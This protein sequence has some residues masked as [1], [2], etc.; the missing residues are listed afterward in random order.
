MKQSVKIKGINAMLVI[1]MIWMGS[2]SY[3][4]TAY[5][6]TTSA[7]VQETEPAS[8]LSRIEIEGIEL[9]Q[10]FSGDLFEYSAAVE[11][12]VQTIKL[13]VEGSNT[14]S[15]ITINGQAV[16]SGTASN[17]S[18]QTVVNIFHISV[19][20][21]SS[22]TN[23]YTLTI[24]REES[25]NNLLKSIELSQ[26][27]LAPKFSSSVTEYNVAVPNSLPN[28]TIK[29]TS[30]D[31][32]STI[33]VNGTPAEKAGVE[34]ELPV[35]KSDIRIEVTAKNSEKKTYTLYMTRAAAEKEKEKD[36]NP[37]LD[38]K[39]DSSQPTSPKN[40]RPSTSQPTSPK[41][42]RPSTSQPTTPQQSSSTLEKTSTA[43]L[44]SLSV[45]E[46]SWDSSF[47]S[48]EFTYHLTASSDVDTVTINPVATYSSSEILTEGS[49]SK[50]VKLDDD[51]KTTIS[52]VVK[53]GD[54]RKTY[55]LVFD[56]ES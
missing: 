33:K 26:G 6:E 16:I 14:D 15:S 25:S 52:I 21:G 49:T 4:P 51:K 24:T 41:N 37:I 46:G 42:N 40:N 8:T 29:P 27:Q 31:P 56:K 12:Q 1:S 55:V 11:N 13:L 3:L 5:A 32:T 53:N 2:S 39:P 9:S 28:I 47:T 38:N 44:A 34:V 17:Y 18:L 50:T 45:S 30:V 19:N 43:L 22:T 7:P 20:D 35:G 54:D 23:S 36:D 10:K 48:E